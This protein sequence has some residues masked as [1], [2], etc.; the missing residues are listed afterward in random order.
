[1]IFVF[2]FYAI[3]IFAS[4]SY[5]QITDVTIA[6]IQEYPPEIIGIYQSMTF[7]LYVSPPPPGG[8]NFEGFTITLTNPN[9]ITQTIGPFTSDPTGS[10]GVS[11]IPDVLGYW[12]AEFDFPG[13]IFG[14]PFREY[15]S[16][17]DIT[18]F[19]VVEEPVIIKYPSVDVTI[20]PDPVGVN[21]MAE[22]ELQFSPLPPSE[23]DVFHDFEVH[24]GSRYGVKSFG[25]FDSSTGGNY[26]LHYT[27]TNTGSFTV[28]ISYPGEWFSV[29][30]LPYG[31]YFYMFG[32]PFFPFTV[33]ENPVFLPLT[34]SAS[35]SGSTNPSPGT[36]NYEP[37]DV[38]VTAFPDP[39][40]KFSYWLLDGENVGTNPEHTVSMFQAHN[41][42]AIFEEEQVI[43]DGFYDLA[44]L[45]SGSG[46]TD[47][48]PGIARYQSGTTLTIT[49]SPDPNWKFSYWLLDG[50][51]V[52]VNP[53]YRIQIDDNHELTAIFELIDND[54]PRAVIDAILFSS[55][56]ESA[57]QGESISF[58]GSGY[59]DGYIVEYRWTSSIDGLLSNSKDFS[60][61]SLSVGTHMIT[62]EVKDTQEVW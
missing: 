5:A 59:D 27:P 13:Q 19:L 44:I 23:T 43:P 39:D 22:I 41:L 7:G 48:A 54:P 55:G 57:F 33:Q 11:F 15:S 47:P 16:S 38:S 40:W 2:L 20:S 51:N 32:T 36:I 60:T 14:D 58:I 42:V 34:I 46:N 8:E 56:G 9:D 30:G 18:Y 50:E 10:V 1:M 24:I 53:N 17:S 21:Q 4:R 26:R 31:E 37:G 61:S 49:A 25:P 62:F 6:E 52:G 28:S 45:V 3:I 35:G 12:S 29:N